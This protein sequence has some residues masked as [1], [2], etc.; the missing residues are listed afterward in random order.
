MKQHRYGQAGR[1]GVAF[2]LLEML[3]VISIISLLASLIVPTF[4]FILERVERSECMNRQRGMGNLLMALAAEKT[5]Y[6]RPGEYEQYFG[7][8]NSFHQWA[9]GVP[10]RADEAW[11]IR[12]ACARHKIDWNLVA[13]PS[14]MIDFMADGVTRRGEYNFARCGPKPWTGPGYVIDTW[15]ERRDD[16]DSPGRG[17]VPF[18]YIVPAGRLARYMPRHAMSDRY[19]DAWPVVSCPSVL[20]PGLDRWFASH[21]NRGVV[22]FDRGGSA[23]WYDLSE[24]A[25]SKPYCAQSHNTSAK[26]LMV[27]PKY[28]DAQDAITDWPESY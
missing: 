12:D 16:P 13:C 22:Q 1:R 24:L 21:E 4:G 2:T 9:G 3:V 5:D 17:W 11:A 23:K 27:A 20:V 6:S 14:T 19:L 26:F 25:V 7:K 15:R 8:S 18:G 10:S 28:R